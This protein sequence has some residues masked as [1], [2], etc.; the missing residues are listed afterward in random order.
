MSAEGCCHVL[1]NNDVAGSPFPLNPFEAQR[2]RQLVFE[3]VVPLK[4][5]WL[6]YRLSERRKKLY[7]GILRIMMIRPLRVVLAVF[8]LTEVKGFTR[9]ALTWQP[10]GAVPVSARIPLL[11]RPAALGSLH[12]AVS[13]DTDTW[14][15]PEPRGKRDII[16]GTLVTA[17]Q[18]VAP[19]HDE[20]CNLVGGACLHANPPKPLH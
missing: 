2:F 13:G 17:S 5:L 8:C 7:I 3:F 10:L 9:G 14:V 18:P 16:F 1:A 12:M 20:G 6:H 11:L 4:A 15:R 19:E